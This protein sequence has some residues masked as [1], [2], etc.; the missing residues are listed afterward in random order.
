MLR[1]KQPE[2]VLYLAV[3]LEAYNSFI[4]RR[5]LPQVSIRE[6]QFKLLVFDEVEEAIVQ[7]IN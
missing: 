7:W 1:I 3:P 2:R 4:S 6:Y 5:Q